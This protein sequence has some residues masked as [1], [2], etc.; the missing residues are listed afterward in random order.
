MWYNLMMC[1]DILIVLKTKVEDT[2]NDDYLV[3]EV[4]PFMC[5]SIG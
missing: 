2:M 3:W 5:S 4:L 1:S